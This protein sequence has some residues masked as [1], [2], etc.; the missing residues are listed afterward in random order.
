VSSQALRYCLVIVLGILTVA[1]APHVHND[2]R[3]ARIS[4]PCFTC[5]HGADDT[6]APQQA[7]ELACRILEEQ[8]SPAPPVHRS[9]ARAR[10]ARARA[11]PRAT[12]ND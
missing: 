8:E 2:D 1:T 4:A 7:P 9:L 3:E 12:L 11:P 5:T 6:L 10:R